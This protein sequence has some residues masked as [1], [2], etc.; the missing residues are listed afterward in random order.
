MFNKKLIKMIASCLFIFILCLGIISCVQAANTENG[1]N[2]SNDKKINT[3]ITIGPKTPGGLKKAI[4]IAKTNDT[5]Y[6]KKGTYTGTKNTGISITKNIT[7]TGIGSKVTIN[8]QGKRRIFKITNSNVTLKKLK[9][10]KGYT[11][12]AGGAIYT[13]NSSLT[14][15]NCIFTN[16]QAKSTSMLY[17]RSGGAICN[18]NEKDNLTVNNCIFTNNKAGWDGGAINSYG[19]TT[20]DNCTFKNNKVKRLGGAI[21]CFNL[22]INNSTFRNN[23]AKRYGGAIICWDSTI[24]NSTFTNNQVERHGGGIYCEDS[25]INK[26]TF[27]NNQAKIYGGAILSKNSTINQCTF[28]KNQAKYG[29]AISSKNSTINNCKFTK[30]QAIG[31]GGAI[32]SIYTW[33]NIINNCTFKNN[34]AKLDG[35]AIDQTGD[36]TIDNCTFINNQAKRNGGAIYNYCNNLINNCT[37]IN[38]LAKKDGGAIYKSDYGIFEVNNCIF[39]TNQARNGGAIF[40]AVNST[41]EKCTFEKN[42]ADQKGGGIYNQA[43]LLQITNSIFKNNI[44]AKNYNAI[45]SKGNVTQKNVTITPK[46]Y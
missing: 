26:C 33:P 16:N 13:K 18:F 29:G 19:K 44:A 22:T 40:S 25:T 27:K 24:N 42:K 31:S 1:T 36:S 6:L 20:I 2:T 3:K 8:A 34:Q 4:K 11:S 30:N 17:Q 37:F 46:S 28:T 23:Q 9:L 14:V 21:Y 32:F 38:N 39:T 5:I 15:K 41:I 45:F 7:I 12:N 10:T 35:G 43:E